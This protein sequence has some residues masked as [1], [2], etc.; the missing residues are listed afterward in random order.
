M[1]KQRLFLSIVFL[2]PLIILLIYAFSYN[3][4]YP[5]LLPKSLTT[6][7][8]D[9][10]TSKES[11]NITFQSIFIGILVTLFT[12]LITLPASRALSSGDFKGKGAFVLLF[13][14]PLILPLAS[15]TMGIH[16]LFIKLH[17][18]NTL[19]GVILINSIPCIP[20]AVRLITNVMTLVGTDYEKVARN[21]GASQFQAFFSIT[22]PVLMPGIISSFTFLFIISF[23]QYF[24][25]FLIGGGKINTLPLVMIPYIQNGDRTLSSAY[26]L[27]FIFSSLLVLVLFEKLL[28]KYYK[29]KSINIQFNGSVN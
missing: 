3:W 25:T 17:L 24:T 14:S 27:L 29:K 23:S 9:A 18:T 2:F 8:F 6:R 13:T 28:E 1:K 26:S 20:Y 19:I 21:L 7:G 10:A 15:I 16:L 12:L 4:E 11:F 22:F 5:N